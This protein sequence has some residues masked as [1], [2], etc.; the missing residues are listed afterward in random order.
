[1]LNIDKIR[2]DFPILA[3]QVYGKPLVYLDNAATSQ[4]PTQV[5]DSLVDYYQRYNSNVHRGVHSLSMEATQRYEEAREKVSS[6]IGAPNPE[7][8]IWVRNTTEAINLVSS[9]WGASQHWPG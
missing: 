7:S 1:M 2:S 4:K 3:Q 6:F 5:I 9:T 8:L